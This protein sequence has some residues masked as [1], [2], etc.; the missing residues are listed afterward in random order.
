VRCSR[1]GHVFV[2]NENEEMKQDNPS[3]FTHPGIIEEE[4]AQKKGKIRGS[5]IGMLVVLCVIMLAS[6]G[7]YWFNYP[8]AS[9]GRLRFEKMEG[10]ET[11]AKD[12]GVFL[13]KGTVYNGSTKSRAFV[14]LKAKLFDAAGTVLTE[15]AV[16]AG[17]QLSKD[18]IEKMNKEDIESRIDFFRKM[19]GASFLLKSRKDIPFTI[20]FLDT[21]PGK[22]KQYSMEILE[23]PRQ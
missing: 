8:G 3:V 13:I 1:C 18:E 19:G 14:M 7:Y 9:I 2:Y 12:G 5:H 20:I 16:L 10:I 6:F 11:Y 17:F 4:K 23:A 22:L 21:F 15:R